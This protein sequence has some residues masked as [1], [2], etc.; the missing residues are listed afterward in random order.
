MLITK[1][2]NAISVEIFALKLYM[3]QA[4]SACIFAITHLEKAMPDGALESPTPSLR[5]KASDIRDHLKKHHPNC[6]NRH[7]RAIVNRVAGRYWV[8]ASIGTAVGI[9]MDGYIRHQLTDYDALLAK[10]VKREDARAKVKSIVD[11]TLKSW[12][13]D[14]IKLNKTE[15]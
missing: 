5:F 6:P 3:N 10:S 11:Y 12:S 13:C 1:I 15:R 4:T 9:V 8:D 7:V 14:A 2:N